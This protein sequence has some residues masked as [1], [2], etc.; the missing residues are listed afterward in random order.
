M[1]AK[2]IENMAVHEQEKVIQHQPILEKQII[3]EHPVPVKHE[4]HIQP[5]VHQVE[6]QIQPIIKTRPPPLPSSKR[7]GLHFVD[8][9]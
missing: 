6:H 4:H 2:C 8:T 7:S 5:Q 9:I 3:N 1:E